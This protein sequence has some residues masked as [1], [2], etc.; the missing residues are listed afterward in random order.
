MQPENYRDRL[1]K[2][3][4]FPLLMLGHQSGGYFHH[5]NWRIL[6]MKFAEANVPHENDVFPSLLCWSRLDYT[7]V[8]Q[9]HL[10]GLSEISFLGS[11]QTINLRL[12]EKNNENFSNDLES[13]IPG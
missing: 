10:S 13:T 7:V 4:G 1:G 9:Q 8:S 3:H 5:N 2:S 6:P 11:F 12:E